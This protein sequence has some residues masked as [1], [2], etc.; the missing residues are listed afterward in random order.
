MRQELNL[1]PWR[2]TAQWFAPQDLLS[3][4]SFTAQDHLPT[5]GIILVFKLLTTIRLFW[6]LHW[7]FDDLVVVVSISNLELTTL[8]SALYISA[9]IKVQA[10]SVSFMWC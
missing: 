7:G 3:L 6:L 9:G 5:V 4:F 8:L 10:I 1:R 2:N